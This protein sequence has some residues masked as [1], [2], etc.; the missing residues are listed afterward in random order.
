MAISRTFPWHMVEQTDETRIFES[1][2]QLNERPLTAESAVTSRQSKTGKG[3]NRQ[4]GIR[5]RTARGRSFVWDI[6]V[7]QMPS[8]VLRF[9]CAAPR[10]RTLSSH[11]SICQSTKRDRPTTHDAAGSNPATLATTAGLHCEFVQISNPN[12]KWL[13]AIGQYCTQEDRK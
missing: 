9:V 1:E 7:L 8:T 10:R 13:S 12:V 11:N 5:R 6:T 2:F 4:R 3:R